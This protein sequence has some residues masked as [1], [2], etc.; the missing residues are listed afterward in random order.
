V[1]YLIVILAYFS[2]GISTA[3]AYA[4]NMHKLQHDSLIGQVSKTCPLFLPYFSVASKYIFWQ[5]L[6]FVVNYAPRN[7]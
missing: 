5:V 3:H 2:L 6:G 4:P 1:A 7:I